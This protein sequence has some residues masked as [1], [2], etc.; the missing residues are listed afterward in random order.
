MIATKNITKIG[1][2]IVSDNTE[3][4]NRMKAYEM[5]EAGRKF[6]PLLPVIA[7]IDGRSFSKFTKGLERPYDIRLSKLMVATTKFLVQETDKRQLWI[8]TIGR[9]HSWLVRFHL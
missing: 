4:G 1:E 9:N 3:I 7:R 6:M 2:V 8:Y 5:A